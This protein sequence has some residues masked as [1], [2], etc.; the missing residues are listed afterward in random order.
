MKADLRVFCSLNLIFLISISCSNQ[1]GPAIPGILPE[2]QLASGS[3]QST[4]LWGYYNVAFDPESGQF[5]YSLDRHAMFT[6]NVVPFL[7]GNPSTI[8]FQINSVV[9]GDDYIDIDFDVSITHPLP[10]M[11]GFNG[12]DVRGVFI[13]VGGARCFADMITMSKY[14]HYPADPE[15]TEHPD[16][17]GSHE[18]M[19]DPLQGDGGGPDG[20]TRWFNPRDFTTPGIFGYTKGIYA[21][22]IYS[23]PMFYHSAEL[24]P[25]KFFADGLGAHDDLMDWLEANP[26]T[27]RVFASGS[28]NTRNYYIRF[29][30]TFV[31]FAYAITANWESKSV[32]PSNMREAVACEKIYGTRHPD[33]YVF[34][35]K[36]YDPKSEVDSG[37]GQMLDYDLNITIV[38]ATASGGTILM[39]WQMVPIEIGDDYCVYHHEIPTSI[40]DF[41]EPYDW[42]VIPSYPGYDYQNE[43]GVPND[44]GIEPLAS[45]FCFELDFSDEPWE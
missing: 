11:P 8:S 26:G 23:D 6:M 41:Y 1:T 38:S 42:W 14:P 12:Y 9:P 29:P 35:F 24:N 21:D 37:S 27:D 40:M 32:H 3:P 44:M 33:Y 43:F 17:P 20:Y 34:E 16:F 5:E 2:N 10:D 45:W 30:K 19:D 15:Y 25:Y 39:D 18:M 31:K 36:I 4:I 13:G 7:N 28:Q 22:A